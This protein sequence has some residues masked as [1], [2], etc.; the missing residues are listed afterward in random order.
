[1]APV[2]AVLEQRQG[3]LRKVSLEVLAAA[4]NVADASGQTV[5]ALLLSAGSVE[6]SDRLGP[7]GADRVLTAT[8]PDFGLYHPDGY[9]ATVAGIGNTYGAIIFAA[10][11]TG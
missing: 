9:S 8:H 4:R 3:S 5:D 11:A 2:L 10:T 7:A 1:M 6:G